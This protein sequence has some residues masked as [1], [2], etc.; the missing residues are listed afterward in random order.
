MNHTQLEVAA[1][2]RP[3]GAADAAALT[4]LLAGLSATSSF[5]RFLAGLGMPNPA[6]VRGLLRDE[7]DRGALL[8]VRREPDGEGV[9]GHAC[10]SVTPAGSADVGVVVA[11]TV[12]G[13]GIGTALFL[14]AV[15]AARAVGAD[16]VHLDVH[17]EN[18]RLVAALRRRFD[19][20]AFG[21]EHGLVGVDVPVTPLPLRAALVAAA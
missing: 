4:A 1:R 17:P 15:D 5:H 3:A 13:R 10:W 21:W 20:S 18:R 8:A 6:L 9:L 11:D 12:Q 7:P 2:I 19:R 14:H 16:A